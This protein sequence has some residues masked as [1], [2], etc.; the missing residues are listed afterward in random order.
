MRRGT[1]EAADGFPGGLCARQAL[2]PT[3]S[4]TQGG[5]VSALEES[6]FRTTVHSHFP[7]VPETLTG[8]SMCG[9]LSG[10]RHLS[11]SAESPKWTV[12]DQFRP[13]VYLYRSARAHR[14]SSHRCN[15]PESDLAPD[16]T[17]ISTIRTAEVSG[18]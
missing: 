9:P 16:V 12:A 10:L 5:L 14:R 17:A 13:K 15:L 6:G 11:D 3:R 4:D 2:A 7:S 18:G 8:A 1:R